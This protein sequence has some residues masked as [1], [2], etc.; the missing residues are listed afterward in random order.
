MLDRARHADAVY[1]DEVVQAF[2]PDLPADA[3]LLE[4]AEGPRRVHADVVDAHH[5]RV[6]VEGHPDAPGLV[7][8][9]C[10]SGHAEVGAVGD[11]G[12]LVATVVRN[13]PDDWAE[14][15]LTGDRHHVVDGREDRGFDEP[16]R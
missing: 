10:L 1:L 15:L 12:R 13:E 2:G 3:R 14:N 9:A 11:P 5:P 7:V 16:A 8:R 6:D 4:A